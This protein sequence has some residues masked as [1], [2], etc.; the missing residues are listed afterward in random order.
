[1]SVSKQLNILFCTVR[2]KVHL[3]VEDD[4]LSCVA[5]VVLLRRTIL[6]PWCHGSA[7]SLHIATWYMTHIFVPRPL[8]MP[9]DYCGHCERCWSDIMLLMLSSTTLQ[10]PGAHVHISYHQMKMTLLLDAFGSHGV[11]CCTCA[12]PT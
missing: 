4:N 9:T 6:L 1:M 8:Y 11:G 5:F 2:P 7:V 10:Q 3:A 12:K